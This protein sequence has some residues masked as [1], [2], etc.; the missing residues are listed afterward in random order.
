M[1]SAHCDRLSIAVCDRHLQ[2]T[3]HDNSTYLMTE[4]RRNL[5]LHCQG[6]VWTDGQVCVFDSKSASLLH[7]GMARI[8][9]SRAKGDKVFTLWFAH[10]IKTE[11][12]VL[13]TFCF[14]WLRLQRVLFH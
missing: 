10:T 14:G 5:T 3:A 8:F 4:P 13:R 12:T 1:A 11:Q 6:A 7:S 9:D 2:K